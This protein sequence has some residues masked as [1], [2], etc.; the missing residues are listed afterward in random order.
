MKA[1][2]GQAERKGRIQCC[3]L[4]NWRSIRNENKFLE[5][6]ASLSKD[7]FFRGDLW[8]SYR[9]ALNPEITYERLHVCAC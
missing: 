1:L 5:A 6:Q 8:V 9:R 4:L 3:E 2:D 7:S